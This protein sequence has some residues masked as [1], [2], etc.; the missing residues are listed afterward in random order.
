MSEQCVIIGAGHGGSQAAASLRQDGYQDRIVLLSDEKDLPYHKPPLSKGFLKSPDIPVLVLRNENFYRENQIELILGASVAGIDHSPMTVRL[1]DGTRIPYT[2]LILATGSR[3]R[4]PA[5][6][7][8]GLAGVLSLRSQADAR[9]LS[10][11]VAGA[12]AVVIIGAGYI[13]MELAHTLQGLGRAVTLLE[14]APR[15]LARSVAP[16]MSD[17]VHARSVKAGIDIV[18]GAR[19]TALKGVGGKVTHVQTDDGRVFPADLVI[20][21]T[22][23]VPNVELAAAAGLAIDNGIVID[24]HMRTS[25]SSILAIGDCVSF[26]QHHADRRLRLESVQNATDQARNAARTLVGRPETYRELPWFWS[27]Q[28]DMKLQSAGLA[29]EADRLITVGSPS[30]NA[31]AIYHYRKGSLIAVD[32]LNRPA[33]H[34]VARR[35]IAAGMSPA[36]D[37]VLA[38]PQRLKELVLAARS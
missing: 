25:S 31:F 9:H 1:A 33:D 10:A 27:D 34:M 12:A 26:H 11:V 24:A 20:I 5:L 17:H 8:I 38:G 37:D 6:D 14:T 30:D 22:G 19:V 13:G 35:L 2:S 16:Q 23:A 36:E 21:A 29:F 15:I 4:L 32:T 7:G 18:L 28:G 3:P